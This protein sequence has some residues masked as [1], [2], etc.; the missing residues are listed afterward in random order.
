MRPRR[1][2]QPPAQQGARG[3]EGRHRLEP[4]RVQLGLAALAGEPAPE[5]DLPA[6]V[7]SL[8]VGGAAQLEQGL[9]PSPGDGQGRG[10]SPVRH[11][12]HQGKPWPGS[13]PTPG[14]LPRSCPTRAPTP[15]LQPPGSGR[16]VPAP[17]LGLPAASMSAD[18]GRRPVVV[19]VGLGPAGPEHTTRAAVE[20]LSSGA[21]RRSCAPRRHPA[22]AQ[23][24][25]GSRTSSAWTTATRRARPSTRCTGR[26]SSVVRGCGRRA[27]QESPTRSRAR[28]Q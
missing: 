5:G 27:R 6:V 18:E 16:G 20:A 9:P 28:R 13:M 22:A 7:P 4:D 1:G 8:V 25:S 14:R 23:P 26:S 12:E 21:G 2:L 3:L 19:V 24:S 17:A 11:L 10:R 15:D